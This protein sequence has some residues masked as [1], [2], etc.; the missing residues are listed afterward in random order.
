MLRALHFWVLVLAAPVEAQRVEGIVEPVAERALPG[1]QELPELTRVSCGNGPT[2]RSVFGSF[3]ISQIR[4][5]C[6]VADLCRTFD[7]TFV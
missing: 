7:S 3:S 4:G 5:I 6:V 1:I 2:F